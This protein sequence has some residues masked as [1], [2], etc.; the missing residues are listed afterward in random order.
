MESRRNFF[1]NQWQLKPKAFQTINHL[2]GPHSI[3]LFAD[4]TT[5]LLPKYV[6]WMPDPGAIHTDAFTIPWNIWTR[7]FANPPWN[8]I[9]RALRKIQ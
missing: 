9:S 7:P 4:R 8:L 6:S 1:K 3:D 5:K 2:W